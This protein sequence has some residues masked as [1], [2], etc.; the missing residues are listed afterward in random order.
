MTIRNVFVFSLG[1][2]VGTLDFAKADTD[3]HKIIENAYRDTYERLI[4]EPRLAE[5]AAVNNAL[6][7]LHSGFMQAFGLPPDE[8]VRANEMIPFSKEEHM[9]YSHHNMGLDS[10]DCLTL[11]FR[12]RVSAQAYGSQDFEPLVALLDGVGDGGLDKYQAALVRPDL[13]TIFVITLRAPFGAGHKQSV[14][15]VLN[16]DSNIDLSNRLPSAGTRK[17]AATAASVMSRILVAPSSAR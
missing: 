12:T 2:D 10:G 13:K 1:V 17:F 15:A 11:G 7:L 6:A 4:Q 14:M 16:F 9:V 5:P 8:L 3:L